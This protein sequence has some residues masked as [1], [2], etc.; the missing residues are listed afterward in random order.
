MGT[1]TGDEI[2]QIVMEM[3]ETGEVF[4]EAMAAVS[5][6][7]AVADL[8]RRLAAQEREHYQKFKAM[9]EKLVTRPPD[10]PLTWDEMVFDQSLIN[11]NVLPSPA[12]ARRVAA[13]GSLTETI[14]LAIQLENNA[15]A[16][17]SA[18]L[19]CV[20]PA[21]ADAVGKI[22]DQERHHAQELTIARRNLN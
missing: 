9:R 6:N 21:D 5:R 2:F 15:V 14:D 13:A 8:C 16:F 20:D 3:E 19:R 18:M 10:R 7:E 4:Y 12:E 22:I 1:Y 17:Y 11:D